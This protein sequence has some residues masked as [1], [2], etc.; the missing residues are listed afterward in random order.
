MCVCMYGACD[1]Q[2]PLARIHTHIHTSVHTHVLVAQNVQFAEPV[3]FFQVPEAHRMH[4]D[5]LAPVKS[6][7]QPLSHTHLSFP[8]RSCPGV[9]VPKSQAKQEPE[10][11]KKVRQR[12]TIMAECVYTHTLARTHAHTHTHVH[13]SNIANGRT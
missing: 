5:G 1:A 7:V 8:L 13:S 6:E 12:H 10:S 3:T 4:T 11:E 9:V 2:T